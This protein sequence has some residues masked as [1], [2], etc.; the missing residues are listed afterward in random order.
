[1]CPNDATNTLGRP[2]PQPGIAAILAFADIFLS[3]YLLYFSVFLLWK[4]HGEVLRVPGELMSIILPAFFAIL[5]YLPT[6]PLTRT[7]G[8]CARIAGSIAL[9]TVAGKLIYLG[10]REQWSTSGVFVLRLLAVS[11]VAAYVSAAAWATVVKA[12]LYRQVHPLLPRMAW[13][14]WL[15][16][17]YIA[18]STWIAYLVVILS[19]DGF[20]LGARGIGINGLAVRATQSPGQFAF[21]VLCLFLLI[22]TAP[23]VLRTYLPM[24]AAKD[25]LPLGIALGIGLSWGVLGSSWAAQAPGFDLVVLFIGAYLLL[26][27]LLTH[28]RRKRPARSTS[29][30]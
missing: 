3:G 9:A 22:T 26:A 29:L 25:S 7:L 1:M 17:L 23:F 4:G 24:G 12:L 21:E 28:A 6:D 16:V 10:I 15:G 18:G 27:S 19:Y 20:L 8:Q 11:F 30:S 5:C 13:P 14:P 2:T